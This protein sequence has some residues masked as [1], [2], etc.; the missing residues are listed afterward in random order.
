[1]CEIQ[2]SNKPGFP[3]GGPTQ[4]VEPDLVGIAAEAQGVTSRA[5]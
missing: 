2:S 4:P 1:M 3:L 5:P